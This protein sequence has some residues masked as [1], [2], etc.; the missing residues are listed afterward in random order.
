MSNSPDEHSIEN[1]PH[2]KKE[3]FDSDPGEDEV[4]VSGENRSE[5][6]RAEQSVWSEPGMSKQLAGP[7]APSDTPYET[8]LR[9]G[10][11]Q[12]SE[13][14]TWMITILIAVFSAPWAVLGALL[15][16][17]QSVF[18]LLS[19]VVFGPFIEEVMK[20][21]IALYVIET[22][23]F[24]FRN[25]AQLLFCAAAGGLGFAI[26]ENMIYLQVYIPNA[27][28]AVINWRWSVCVAL[29]TGC[30]LIAGLGLLNTWEHIWEEYKPA[31]LAYG[32]PYLFTAVGLHGT[33]NLL[34]IL[35]ERLDYHF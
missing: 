9:E 35:L 17:Q 16:G 5:R 30:S 18:P 26:I 10:R 24:W 29:H 22:R 20:V 27:S 3:S 4:D 8:W 23:P 12:H 31:Q 6:E 7:T 25:R 15:G 13:T 11:E 32:F 33:Y 34:A 2:R 21:G 1:E 19:L 14:R 28:Q